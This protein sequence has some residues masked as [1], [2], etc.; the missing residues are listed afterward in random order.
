MGSNL[1]PLQINVEPWEPSLGGL[2]TIS[3]YHTWCYTYVKTHQH[4]DVGLL[5]CFHIVLQA[6]VDPISS[7]LQMFCIT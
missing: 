6:L 1:R 4:A 7:R 5:T 2:M 3:L